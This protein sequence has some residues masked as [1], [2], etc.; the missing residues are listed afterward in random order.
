M[1][2]SSVI[3]LVFFIPIVLVIYNIVPKILKN[4]ILL[5]A[6]LIFY[7]WGAPKFVFFLIASTLVDF[8]IAKAIWN[9]ANLKKK[10]ILISFSLIFNL[11]V[12]LYFKYTNFFIDNLNTLFSSIG[13]DI[14]YLNVLLPIGISFYTFQTITYLVDVYRGEQEPQSNPF[15]YLLYI[16]MFPQL[17]AG[18]IVNY[19]AVAK[20][21]K[22]RTETVNQKITGLIRFSIGLS[23]KVLI[24]NILGAEAD[25][26]FNLNVEELNVFNSW[27]GALLYTM[28]IYF[29]FSGYS[30]MAIGLGQVFGF[31][32]PENFDNPYTSRTISEF[33]RRWH[34]TL[35]YFMKNYLYI[36]LGGNRSS[37]GRLYINLVLVF[38]ISGF[39]HG[40]N[41]TFICW[42]VFHGLFLILD[43]LFIK[44]WSTKIGVLSVI[45]TFIAVVI[46][47]VLFRS[48]SMDQAIQ[49]YNHMF[50][51]FNITSI[52][53]NL[54]KKVIIVLSVALVI[55]FITLIK[56]MVKVQNF[57]LYEDYSTTKNVVLSG[58]SLLM[59]L[60]CIGEI[61]A[62]DFNPFIYFRF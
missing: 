32:F 14:P 61:S 30:D 34:M 28:Q 18:P 52:E 57:L 24:A 41:W 29:D 16:F 15:N 31:K 8:F 4:Y 27:F 40:A 9:T 44:K 50:I 1:V 13:L 51:D 3:F 35:G 38:I 25:A 21:I 56:P 43:R 45:P 55:S 42:G 5:L 33:W 20:E 48:E 54:S 26:I 58:I 60:L 7:A 53:F 36:P 10:K 47:W 6:S 49:V 46:G 19:G 59:I 37:K 12:L 11:G 2:F 17:I 22:E 39:W 62:T 23:K